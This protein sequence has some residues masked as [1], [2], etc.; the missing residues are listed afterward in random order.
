[1]TRFN[2]DIDGIAKRVRS[3]SDRRKAFEA[4]TPL[5]IFRHDWH[6]GERTFKDIRGGEIGML[7]YDKTPKFELHS[8]IYETIAK[9]ARLLRHPQA[10]DEASL[11]DIDARIKELHQKR[12]EL[13]DGA[14]W[15]GEVVTPTE[16]EGWVAAR[17]A[18]ATAG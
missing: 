12:R 8:T 7:T 10:A 1:M 18:A 9:G 5:L 15:R 16:V 3:E 17:R 13:L 14:W 4:T 11:I 6:D 2:I